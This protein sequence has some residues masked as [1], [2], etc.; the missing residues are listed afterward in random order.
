MTKSKQMTCTKCGETKDESLFVRDQ[1]RVTGRFPWCKAC[2]LLTKQSKSK[3]VFSGNGT[4]VCR[5]CLNPIGGTH[6][7]RLY[8][9][10][11]CKSKATS[12][13]GYGLSPD[14]YRALVSRNAGRCPICGRH[15]NRWNIDH[16]HE[17][18][19]TYG[20]ICT[21]CNNSVLSMLGHNIEAAKR[22]V[23]YLEHPPVREMLGETR[24][25]GP[26][27][28]SQLHRRWLWSAKHTPDD[29]L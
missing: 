13:K 6:S 3:T 20:A 24:F 18:G 19:E 5:M 9:G 25:T 1:T 14:E 4:K 26:T 23:L 28:A 22:L 17:T 10:D 12:L 11:R 16:N 27:Q 29:P 21:V 7:N 2:V 15:V 8:C